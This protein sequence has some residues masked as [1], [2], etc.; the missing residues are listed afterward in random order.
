MD[1]FP[2]SV[3]KRRVELELVE[4]GADSKEIAT[5]V[6]AI[7]CAFCMEAERQAAVIARKR[8]AATD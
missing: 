3:A 5:R 1:C 8:Y 4:R 2:C 6:N 7:R